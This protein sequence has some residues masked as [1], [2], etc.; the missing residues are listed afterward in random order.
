ML[1]TQLWVAGA[2]EPNKIGRLMDASVHGDTAVRA[3]MLEPNGY[4]NLRA[5]TDGSVDGH[6]ER[7]PLCASRVT[8]F[9]PVAHYTTCS[10][11]GQKRLAAI[12]LAASPTPMP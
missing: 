9:D 4:R 2:S 6:T 8:S 10:T 7:N 1:P 11:F 12:A 5:S 3:V